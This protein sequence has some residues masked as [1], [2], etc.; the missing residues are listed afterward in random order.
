MTTV[1]ARRLPTMQFQMYNS[2]YSIRFLYFGQLVGS[3]LK[4]R[5]S[6]RIPEVSGIIG[7]VQ[8]QA[9]LVCTFP[10]TRS[11]AIKA[12]AGTLELPRAI[13]YTVGSA[14]DR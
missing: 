5:T 9:F 1:A 13:A 8:E 3:I 14:Y 4:S 10:I 11:S 2:E 12:E 7:T 6:L